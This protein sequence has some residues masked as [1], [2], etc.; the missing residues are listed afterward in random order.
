MSRFMLLDG[1]PQAQTLSSLDRMSSPDQ[2]PVSRAAFQFVT[3]QWN[4]VRLAGESS[5][6][7]AQQALEDL[8]RSY[9]Y[10][11][12]GFVRRQGCSPAD[13]QDLTQDFFAR[14]LKNNHVRL[15]T[16]ERGHFRTFLL[17]CLKHFL[18]NERDKAK[19]L[20]RGGGQ[21]IA[22]LDE[23]GAE[24][25]FAAETFAQKPPDSLYDTLWANTLLERALAQLGTELALAGK[26]TFF[27]ELKPFIWGDRKNESYETVGARLDMTEGALKVAVYRL[28]QRFGELLRAEV[29]RTVSTPGEIEDELRYLIS[30]V[31]DKGDVS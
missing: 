12:Y 19:R 10:P 6:A 8:C 28:R 27:A 22:S 29:A 25:R 21:E 17:T 30:V 7:E 16:P 2:E 3:T 23:E 26:S 31:R 15:A 14:F 18:L 9:W 11:L 13:A 1:H 4:V 5:S 24:N 20:K